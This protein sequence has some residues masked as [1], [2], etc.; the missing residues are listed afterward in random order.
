[1]RLNRAETA[2]MNNRVR[3]AIQR[4]FEAARLLQLGGPVPAGAALEIGCGRGVGAELVLDLFEAATVDAFDLDP[5]MVQLARTRLRPR[6]ARARLWVGD[7]TAI[8]VPDAS[9]DAVFDFGIVHHVPRWRLALAEVER[10]LKP[11]GRFYAEEVLV[12]FLGHPLV[13]RLFEHPEADRFDDEAFRAALRESG[14]ELRGSSRLLRSF[15]WFVA[16]KP[17]ARGMPPARL[18]RSRAPRS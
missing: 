18:R 8:P 3:A 10:V 7:A 15:A 1:M 2:L 9:Y 11:G 16:E 13:K 14:L 17:V 6:G 5:R 4:R 12:A